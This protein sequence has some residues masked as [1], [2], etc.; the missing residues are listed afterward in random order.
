MLSFSD[1]PDFNQEAWILKTYQLPKP[2]HEYACIFT[3]KLEVF[4]GKTSSFAVQRDSALGKMPGV[5][6]TCCK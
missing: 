6:L 5:L 3:L 2:F 4:K 1:L